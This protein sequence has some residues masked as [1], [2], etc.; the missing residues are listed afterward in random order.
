MT[1]GGS[2][3]LDGYQSALGSF[4]SQ[5]HSTP[6]GLSTGSGAS[7]NANS[8]ISVMGPTMVLGRLGLFPSGPNTTI[9]GDAHPGPS[10]AV[11]TQP[12]TTIT[13]STSPNTKPSALPDIDVPPI[14]CQ[15]SVVA[16]S[17]QM[18]DGDFCYDSVRVP[19]GETLRVRG[20]VTVV[21]SKFIMDPSSK[22]EVDTTDGPVLMYVTDCVKCSTGSQFLSVGGDPKAFGMLVSAAK[23]FDHDGD[24]VT[25]PP[26]T[27][28][29]TGNFYGVLYAPNAPVTVPSGL[30]IFGSVAAQKLTLANNARVTFDQSLL[31]CVSVVTN[32]PNF[33]S[34]KIVELPK[35]PIV[36]SR[37]DPNAYLRDN[38]IV[39]IKAADAH[40]E[41]TLTILYIDCSGVIKSFT[42]LEAAFDWSQVR[43]P[44]RTN[45]T[46]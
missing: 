20:P 3:V 43:R 1:I 2:A 29:S 34:W 38:A 5:A 23:A 15:G 36:E 16:H 4:E 41:K 25:D 6:V 42:G 9:Y 40:R 17:T 44:L 33:I 8:N 11:T 39:P 30:R 27:L 22:I 13:G 18:K 24:G 37:R 26:V 14:K 46:L 31:N 19:A 12:Y 32:L 21:A 7:I 35:V 28:N 10:K 45:W